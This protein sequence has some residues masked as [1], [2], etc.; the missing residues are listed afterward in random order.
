MNHLQVYHQQ[1]NSLVKIVKE[2]EN[3]SLL[4]YSA[5]FFIENINFFTK[6]FLVTICAYLESFIKDIAY[7]TIQEYNDKLKGLGIPTNLTKW[8]FN[9][10]KKLE[11]KDLKYTELKFNINKKDLDNYVSGNPNKTITLFN[12]IGISL[13]EN[14]QFNELKEVI[15]IIIVKRNKILHYNDSASD[16]SLSDIINYILIVK[17]YIGAINFEVQKKID[18]YND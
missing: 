8:S 7:T 18:N 17:E 15:N 1:F 3:K 10:N 16:I 6:S 5:P 9:P 13:T 2:V 11:D 12:Q 14:N 4:D